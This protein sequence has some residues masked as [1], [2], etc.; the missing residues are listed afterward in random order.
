MTYDPSIAQEAVDIV[1]GDRAAAYGHPYYDFAKVAGMWSALFGWEVT[2]SDVPL[3]M[4]CLK[5]ARQLHR[6]KR[7]NLVDI[8]GYV[9]THD[10]ALR[11]QVSEGQILLD[12]IELPDISELNRRR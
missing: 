12:E 7:D 8:V 11:K 5:L 2:P 3:A 10:A 9:I 4:V 6:E 1:T